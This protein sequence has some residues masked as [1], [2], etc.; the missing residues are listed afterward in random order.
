M[1]IAIGVALVLFLVLMAIWF[2]LPSGKE[3]I[4]AALWC[5]AVTWLMIQLFLIRGT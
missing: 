5:L 2:V 4:Q 1:T 3:L